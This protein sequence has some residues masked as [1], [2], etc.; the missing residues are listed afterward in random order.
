MI[1]LRKLLPLMALT[2]CLG[3]LY[4]PGCD[5]LI[6]EV[7]EFT[8]AGHPTAEFGIDSLS[9]DSG[10][11]PLIVGF[12]DKSSGPHQSWFWRFGDGDS[13]LDT[14]PVHT[15]DEAGT[16]TVSLTITDT[17]VDN[18]PGGD[19]EVKNRF[20]IVGTTIDSFSTD[21]V[22][23]CPGMEVTFTPIDYGGITSYSWDFGDSSSLSSDSNPSHIYDSTGSY[24]CTL[25][26]TGGCGTKVIGYD[27]LIKVLACPEPRIWSSLRVICNDED[28]V[29]FIDTTDYSI[30]GEPII[31]LWNFG[32]SDEDTSSAATPLK[33]YS[34]PGK[35][36]VMLSVTT[37]DGSGGTVTATDSIENYITAYG[38][39]SAQPGAV[40]ATS[41][42]VDSLYK[43]Q[44]K[45]KIDSLNAVD[46]FD[47]V[48]LV[49]YFG[50]GTPPTDPAVDPLPL[51]PVH[52]YEVPG[53][54]DVT[55]ISWTQC[56]DSSA[57]TAVG[58]VQLAGPLLDDSAWFTIDSNYFVNV[59]T[60]IDT[61][62]DTLVDPPDTTFDFTYNIVDSTLTFIFQDSSQ[63]FV[64][65]WE[66]DFGDDNTGT[67][68]SVG[69]SY[70]VFDT[71][72]VTMLII[73]DCDSASVTRT[74]IV[75]EPPAG[76]ST[77]RRYRPPD[78]K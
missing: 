7:N 71:L 16:Y 58:F 54:Y 66:W 52:T 43:F 40:S 20:I 76:V 69:H 24:A 50:D 1:S 49:W 31:R 12:V 4:L 23:G 77:R 38:S 65:R 55:L 37:D 6:T 13:S 27:S 70:T 34:N 61:I 15:Y 67:G 75:E 42:C 59:D 53:I 21:V 26:V 19:V 68:D 48:R 73:N 18:E 8:I 56:A 11:T 39:P 3:G 5:T 72:D 74:V 10:C 17:T 28:T 2:I 62:V 51:S 36:T 60:L 45:F 41:G 33:V 25:T 22:Q 14:N 78:K 32:E 64:D 57:A 35:Y 30:L 9:V 29:Q 47:Y 63:G 44:V 46:N